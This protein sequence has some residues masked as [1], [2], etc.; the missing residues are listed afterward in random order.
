MHI[1]TTVLDKEDFFSKYKH[2]GR[3]K[4][5]FTKRLFSRSRSVFFEGRSV[6]SRG[7]KVYFARR[8]N[9]CSGGAN[10]SY[11]NG[12]SEFSQWAKVSFARGQSVFSPGAKVSYMSDRSV[13]S[14]G[15]CLLR[16]DEVFFFL[17]RPKFL[18]KAAGVY[19][20]NRQKRLFCEGT[21]RLS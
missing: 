12:R 10:V 6:F 17:E 19:F 14:R 4:V 7:A 8:R 20:L 9:V 3:V 21:K 18:I 11:K 5:A 2:F 1:L 15:T 13:F 16:F